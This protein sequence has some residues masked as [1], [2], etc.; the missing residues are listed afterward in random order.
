MPSL[1]ARIPWIDE[2]FT[3]AP[4][5]AT[6]DELPYRRRAPPERSEQVHCD[7]ALDQLPI[8]IVQGS[9]ADDARVVDPPEQRGDGRCPAHGLG[10]R[11]RNAHVAG[12]DVGEPVCAKVGRR[13]RGRAR[14]RRPPAVGNSR[15]SDRVAD[16]AAAAGDDDAAAHDASHSVVVPRGPAR[17]L[18]GVGRRRA[19]LSGRQR[20]SPPSSPR[21]RSEALPSRSRCL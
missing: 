8:G 3:I 16:A 12:H 11:V 15:V 9:L 14:S 13:G 20:S 18:A 10:M 19:M 4:P 1:T 7:G 2:M 5:A 6:C 17:P 21:P